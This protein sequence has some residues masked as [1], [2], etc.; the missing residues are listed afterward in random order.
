M[1]LLSFLAVALF[2][3]AATAC[4]GVSA[5]SDGC[6]SQNLRQRQVIVERQV[7]PQYQIV[8]RIK[9]VPAYRQQIVRERIVKQQRIVQKQRAPRLS[10]LRNLQLGNRFRGNVS[11][12]RE[13]IVERSY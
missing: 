2:A 9:E 7:Q 13:R 11:V 10:Q 6:Y 8:E 5:L 12:R 1:R 3:S 4:D